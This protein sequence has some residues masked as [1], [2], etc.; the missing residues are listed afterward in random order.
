MTRPKIPKAITAGLILAILLDTIVQISWKLAVSE[1]PNNASVP[2]VVMGAFSGL[3]FYVALLA[4]AAQFFNWMHILAHTDVSFALPITACSYITVLAI[5]R[6]SL[7]EALSLTKVLGVA[8]ILLGVIF[9]S[10]TSHQ[11]GYVNPP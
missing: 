6:H 8:M 7:N 10:R 1:I 5:S 9:I 4:F 11:T 2:A 3:F